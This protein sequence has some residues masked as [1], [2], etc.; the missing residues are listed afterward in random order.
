MLHRV[1]YFCSF[2][3]LIILNG[4]IADNHIAVP[5]AS[6]NAISA[7]FNGNG[8][9]DLAVLSM[10]S[11][12]TLTTYLNDGSGNFSQSQVFNLS[13]SGN[14]L[15]RS[16]VGYFSSQYLD[17]IISDQMSQKFIIFSNDGT[18]HFTQHDPYLSDE[19]I[20]VF[21]VGNF[22][23]NGLR[24]IAQTTFGKSELLLEFGNGNNSFTPG[25]SYVFAQL[26]TFVAAGDLRQKGY[27]DIVMAYGA[28]NQIQVFFND[29]AGNFTASNLY[30]VGN[31]P[32]GLAVGDLNNDGY[33]DIVVSNVFD[34]TVSV[35]LNQGSSNPGIFNPATP[36]ATTQKAPVSVAL[37]KTN[38]TFDIVTTNEASSTVSRFTNHGD[39]TF[40]DAIV[41]SAT[42]APVN[43]AVGKSSYFVINLA[44]PEIDVNSLGISTT[45]LLSQSSSISG[46]EEPVTFTATIT[47]SEST[48][49]VPTGTV[50]FY[51]GTTLIA[52]E[53]LSG[54]TA[55]TTI[56]TLTVGNHTITAHYSGDSHFAPSTSSAII[57]EVNNAPS[58]PVD[59]HGKQK[60]HF[61][62]F[63]FPKCLNILS[64]EAPTSGPAPVAYYI[65]KH[66]K[67]DKLIGRVNSG[68]SDSKT[69]YRF[70]DRRVKKGKTI[71]YHIVSVSETGA[72]STPVEVIV[73]PK[74][75]LEVSRFFRQNSGN[76]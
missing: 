7:D 43:I 29:G 69:T 37:V 73:T 3:C 49:I 54:S 66:G 52:S 61:S 57:H 34:N 67:H 14:L 25:P 74:G 10:G 70:I 55:S 36:Y 17:I 60:V 56:S 42:N 53:S 38:G 75:H 72:Q 23:G 41:S 35:L 45:T 30:D 1:F 15:L 64:W 9:D 33:P 6:V 59:V 22:S 2:L 28:A 20:C 65:Y 12:A 32:F 63:K 68:L 11:P 47:P 51:D 27:D 13:F 58:P 39:G 19:H 46:Y 24:D 4:L 62:C 16:A 8:S 5:P 18:G 44:S 48:S 71:T 21:C 26:P 31:G 40:S 76:L 50:A